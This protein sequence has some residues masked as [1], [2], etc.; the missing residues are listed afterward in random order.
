MD[1]LNR[2]TWPGY[3]LRPR[4]DDPNRYEYG[5][6]PAPLFE[7]LRKAILARQLAKASIR[8]AGRD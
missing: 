3:D 1:E 5:M 4:P 8:I 2:F 6:L 7:A